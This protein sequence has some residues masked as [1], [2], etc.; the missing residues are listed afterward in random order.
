MNRTELA[1]VAQS[2]REHAEIAEAF[3]RGP[4][5]DGRQLE[6]ELLGRANQIDARIAQLRA[7]VMAKESGHVLGD[8]PVAA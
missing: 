6:L 4:M 1:A 7:G 8:R 2:I 5:E 3:L